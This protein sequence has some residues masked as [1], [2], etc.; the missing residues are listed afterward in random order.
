MNDL[1][2]ALED[3]KTM[4]SERQDEICI[5]T[6]NN[7]FAGI[8][9]SEY[10]DDF[11]NDNLADMTNNWSNIEENKNIIHSEIDEFVNDFDKIKII[12]NM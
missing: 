8:G 11:S 1:V 4:L 5:I 6:D 9:S 3:V 10:F 7:G 2:E 12:G